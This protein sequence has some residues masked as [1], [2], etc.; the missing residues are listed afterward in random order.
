VGGVMLLAASTATAEI[1]RGEQTTHT[2]DVL[3]GIKFIRRLP[4]LGSRRTA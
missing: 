1:R 3:K 2:F 4:R